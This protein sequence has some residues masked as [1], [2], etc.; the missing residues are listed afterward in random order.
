MKWLPG[1]IINLISALLTLF[2][3]IVALAIGIK[4]I[5]ETRNI[6]SREFKYRLLNEISNWASEHAKWRERRISMFE[7][8]A[9]A[10]SKEESLRLMHSHIASVADGLDGIKQMNRYISKAASKIDKKLLYSVNVLI[11]D[12]GVGTPGLRSN[13]MPR[14]IRPTSRGDSK[15]G[16]LRIYD[17]ILQRFCAPVMIRIWNGWTEANGRF[18][19]SFEQ[20]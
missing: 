8:I 9:R 15:M 5:K 13:H 2:A 7:N 12:I 1:D 11:N 4:S 16:R 10:T 19:D 6:Q 14:K 20:G 3:V 17:E 18:C